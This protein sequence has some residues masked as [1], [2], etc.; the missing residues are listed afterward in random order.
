MNERMLPEKA[1]PPVNL[2]N[3]LPGVTYRI[4]LLPI[5]TV[6]YVSKAVFV[7]LG[8]QPE[9]LL[10]KPTDYYRRFLVAED[11]QTMRYKVDTAKRSR[12]LEKIHL[13]IVDAKGERKHVEDW[14]VGVF[15]DDDQLIAIEGYITEI[16]RSA[17]KWHLLNQLKA[18]RKAIDVNI[19]SS[20]TDTQGVI[21]YANENFQ[22]ISKY[23]EREL[24]GQNHRIVRSG[25]HPK[26]FFSVLWKTIASGKRWNGEIMNRAKDG[27]LYWVDTVIIPIFNEERTITSYLSLRTLITDRKK[28]EQQK[29]GYIHVLEEIAHIVAHD[30]RGPVCSIMGLTN[31]IHTFPDMPDKL[32]QPLDYLK[33]ATDRLDHLTHKLSDKIYSTEMDLRVTKDKPV[34]DTDYIPGS[35][36]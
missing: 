2:A 36:E 9:D 5:P 29:D 8:I 34:N 13:Q 17:T 6:S 26:D 28:A 4:N 1:E 3:A 16:R 12:N 31:L 25:H 14:F 7:L 35:P 21:I 27:T 33:V 15:N 30:V 24:I 22:R 18:Y 11:Q 20:I 19:I 10:F 23:S 32:K